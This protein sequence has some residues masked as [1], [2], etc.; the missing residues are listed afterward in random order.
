LAFRHL[1]FNCHLGFD[2]RNSANGIATHLSGARNDTPSPSCHCEERS[3]EA[4][5]VTDTGDCHAEHTGR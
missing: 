5:L 1:D 2:I 4:I 3:D